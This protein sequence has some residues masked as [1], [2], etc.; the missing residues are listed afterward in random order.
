MLD[1]DDTP[2]WEEDLAPHM[3]IRSQGHS[4]TTLVVDA[5]GTVVNELNLNPTRNN[6][7]MELVYWRGTVAAPI[8]C[9]G[10]ALWNPIRGSHHS[11][12]DLPE[13]QDVGRMAWYHCIAADVCG[14]SREEIILYNPW[15]TSIYI[16]TQQDNADAGFADSMLGRDSIIHA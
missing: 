8:L 4:T 3:A 1:Q 11:L 14:D 2:L 7:G 16:Y 15:S 10:G 6:T 5:D 9:N 13:P 12:P